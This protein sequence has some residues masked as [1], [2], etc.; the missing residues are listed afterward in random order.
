[1]RILSAGVARANFLVASK[2]NDDGIEKGVK[3]SL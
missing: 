2:E 3:K 1:M